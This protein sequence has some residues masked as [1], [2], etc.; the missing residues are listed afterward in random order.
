MT[1][2]EFIK[3]ITPEQVETWWS[4][5]AP[6]EAPEKAEED[7][8]KYKLTKNGKIFPFKYTVKELAKFV[9]ADFKYFASNVGN[10]DAFCN[11]FDFEI[12]EDLV[13][14]NTEAQSFISFYKSLKQTSATLQVSVDYLSAIISNNQINPYK[15]R[16]ALR[17]AKKQIAV[18]IGMRIVF[19][20]REEN[21]KSRIAMVLDKEIYENNRNK[22]D[23]KL[24]ETFKA[25]PEGKVLISFEINDWNEIPQE[26]L[27][28]NIQE[29]LL[30]YNTIKDTKRATWNNEA[31]TTNSVLKYLIFKGKNAA[32]WVEENWSKNKVDGNI[33]NVKEE[34][35]DWMIANVSEGNYFKNQFGSNRA[36]FEKEIDSY[37]EIYKSVFNTELFFINENDYKNQ[38]EKIST[39]IY[40]K[41]TPFDE[42]N[43]SHYSSRPSAILGK[44]NYL[45]F[46]EE[47]FSPQK[48]INYWIFQG[49]PKEFDIVKALEGNAL[50]TWRV[51]AH[52]DKIKKGDKVILWSGGKNAGVYALATVDSDVEI[53]PEPEI[54][55]SYY[56]DQ[57]VYE[58]KERVFLKV[59]Y[60]LFS[61]PVLKPELE[62]HSWFSKM[63]VGS[64]GTNFTAT[65]EEYE[66][67]LKLISKMN[68]LIINISW[69]SKDWKEESQD[70][71]NHEWVKNGGVPYESWNFASAAKENTAEH[72]F[73]YAKFTNN[74][75]ITGTSIFIFYSDKK[76]VGFYGNGAIVEKKVDDNTLNLRGDQNL[77]FVLENKIDNIIEKGYL[78]DGKRIGQGGFNYL[79]KNETVIKI[80]N[81]ALNLNPN[82]KDEITRLKEWFMKEIMPNESNVSNDTLIDV[83]LNQ[84]LYGP[85]GT[86]KTYNT[87]LEA[88]KIITRNKHITYDE[89]LD[90]FNEN[91]SN[92]IE[93]ITFH[94][95]YSYEDFIQGIRPDTE[96]G[97][98]LTFEKKDGVF[99]RIADRA[100]KNLVASENPESAKKEFDVVFQELIQPLNDGDV[101]EVEIK[102]K[103]SS[104]FITTIGEKS[105]EFRKNIGDS[106]H[107]LSINTLRKMY[108]K[109]IND[110]IL[111]G[112][113]PYY[114]PILELL[115]EKGKS[116]ATKI[117][118]KNYVIIIDEINRANI[119]R[120]F[121]E[122]ITLIEDDKRYG[123]KIPMRV[124]LPSGDPFIVPSNLYIIG[125]M[126]TAD[127]SI[128]L[129][130]IALRRRF[131]FVPKYPDPTVAGVH[132]SEIL[133]LLNKAVQSRKGYDFTIGHAYFMGN[134]Y[135]LENTI[136]KKVIPLLLEYFM[137]NEDEVIKIFKE[138]NITI[139]DWPLKMTV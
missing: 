12:V 39:N 35:I 51:K 60:N 23:V 80:L 115:L 120:V 41:A 54:E 126:N 108:D 33:I 47:Q 83:P 59:D 117:E 13:Y 44:K 110:T 79:H 85:P 74:P 131:E 29:L 73:G 97:N 58:D 26:I 98:T 123:R 138:A 94:Q 96:N 3:A 99:K 121:G 111:G 9:N 130:D 81:E 129:L 69:N 57:T 95:N 52:K 125:T 75:K 135:T 72:L 109:G 8:W 56:K 107:T 68:K 1:F 50:K 101:A 71:S 139:G 62:N 88:A 127:K 77:S 7:N 42:Y 92:Q 134:D 16:M 53:L 86:G 100:L 87:V 31:N 105:I 55:K 48:T 24:E 136:N 113:Q 104:F 6:N 22:L 89:A 40:K 116:L 38:I 67:I 30:Q 64:Q 112:L 122:L 37:K 49:N 70:K 93:F 46:L 61:Q 25:K 36:K 63:K 102:M 133:A 137:N 66:S 17:E 119:S 34:F 32:D 14:D 106:E 43:K 45:R 132:D 20:L 103:K 124:T 118:R 15:I 21:G 128:A 5:I 28:N 27:E 76:I 90:K 10:R 84:I 65:K 78:E 11:A 19:A 2:N 4:T 82:Q 114:N 91:L 18:I